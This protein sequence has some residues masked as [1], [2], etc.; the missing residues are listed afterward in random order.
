MRDTDHLLRA[1]S[2]LPT[3]GQ[4]HS[5]QGQVQ[6]SFTLW[7]EIIEYILEHGI[8]HDLGQVKFSPSPNTWIISRAIILGFYHNN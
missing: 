3:K 7:I 8:D 5:H 6:D 2:F 1:A 4:E